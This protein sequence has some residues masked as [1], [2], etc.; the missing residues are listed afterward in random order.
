MNNKTITHVIKPL[1]INFERDPYGYFIELQAYPTGEHMAGKWFTLE[2]DGN[3]E[4]FLTYH[5]DTFHVEDLEDLADWLRSAYNTH[6][7]PESYFYLKDLLVTLF[8]TH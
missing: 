3:N 2:V 7:E 5:G 1:G 4:L 8:N 6:L